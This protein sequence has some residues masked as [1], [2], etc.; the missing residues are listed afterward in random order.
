MKIVI[1]GGHGFIGLHLIKQLAGHEIAVIDPRELTDEEG[2]FL[3]GQKPC[4][5]STHV[6]PAPQDLLLGYP[7]GG[8]WDADVFVS[9]PGML[10]SGP[11]IA[12]PLLCV[13]QSVLS[14]MWLLGALRDRGLS[15]I[16]VFPSSDLV[17][18][19]RKGPA[20][21]MYTACK[22]FMEH[23]LEVFKRN[24]GIPFVALRMATGYG[25]MQRR[26]SVVNF[27]I[28]RALEGK[29][30]PVWGDG[31]NRQ[32]FIYADDMARAFAMACDGKFEGVQPLV[33][34]NTRIADIAQAVSKIVG[35]RVV[36]VPYPEDAERVSVGDL[37][38]YGNPP[39]FKP[40]V[41]LEEGVARTAEWMRRSRTS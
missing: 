11:S 18:V 30:I 22:I 15:P 2:A 21:C 41:D 35:G 38:V 29:D 26:D 33:G 39:G 6:P 10:G 17:Y 5:I 20:R 8:I 12:D 34:H 28:R 13:E 7:Y 23:A 31:L 40:E 25:P 1:V 36:H 27:Y 3:F 16:V 24:F 14:H 19:T 37:P 4:H 9:L 32:A